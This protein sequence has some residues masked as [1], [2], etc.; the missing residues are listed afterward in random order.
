MGINP[1]QSFMQKIIIN[2]LIICFTTICVIAAPIDE[3]KKLYK[4]GNYEAAIKQLEPLR[5]KSPRDGTINYY[6]GASLFEL[7]RTAEAIAPL[8]AAEKKGVADAS[9]ML[10]QMAFDRYDVDAADNYIENWEE[11][12]RK[13]KNADLTAVEN[14]KSK[15]VMMRNM[16]DRVER[17]EIIDSIN[18]DSADFFTHYRLSPE[19]GKLLIPE[20]ADISARTVVYLPQ[21]NKEMI[22]AESDSTGT[23][24]LMSASILDDG[25]IDHPS[26]L[27]GD[28]SEGGDADFPFQM[29]DGMTLYFAATGDTSLG[30]Y[31][32]FLTRR[33]DNGY[34]QPQNMGMP[35]NTPFNDY[36]L[37]ID[38]T[39]GAGWFA[40]DRTQI[41]GKV[42]IY[43][44]I[45]SQTRV[46][47]EADD[48]VLADRAR[49]TSIADTQTDGS[50][51]E[52]IKQHIASIDEGG[53]GRRRNA[54]AFVISM[55]NG[56]VYTSLDDFT[57]IQAKKEM[58]KLLK[59]EA[60]TEKMQQHLEELR[61]RYGRG[62]K[63]VS[64]EI[65]DLEASI[66]FSK[67][68]I[69]DQRNK[70]IRLETK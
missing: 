22:W 18:V 68:N 27:Q 54:K 5:K 2:L 46:N 29:P 23:A 45:T 8:E 51:R 37:A 63:S 65:L 6:L 32:I 17:I 38:E 33:S 47:Y 49:I 53:T 52:K 62:D 61:Y 69:A 4:S 10:A 31:D 12:L 14:M 26:E 21:N 56:K 39:T 44:F 3:A 7:G 40:S 60:E 24:V 25:T 30:G 20:D 11:K 50:N 66:E 55:G 13:N 19:A 70:V 16:L 28:F 15:L 57:N 48:P 43:T 64:D 9:R 34:L 42:T 59:S 41:P 35:Y 67:E 36:M 1:T 58:A